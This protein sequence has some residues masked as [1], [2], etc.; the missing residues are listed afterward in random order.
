MDANP[1][2]K[3]DDCTALLDVLR[4]DA[5]GDVISCI[6]TGKEKTPSVNKSSRKPQV[7]AMFV[8]E[9]QPVTSALSHSPF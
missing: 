4:P 9:I 3:D 5:V 1:L 8:Q 7:Y 6:A 2:S